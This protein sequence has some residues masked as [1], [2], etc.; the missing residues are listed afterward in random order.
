M[1][2]LTIR[3]IILS[4]LLLV[5]S[6]SVASIEEKNLELIKDSVAIVDFSNPILLDMPRGEKSNEMTT[7]IRT[8]LKRALKDT[9]KLEV[10]TLYTRMIAATTSEEALRLNLDMLPVIEQTALAISEELKDWTALEMKGEEIDWVEIVAKVTD[11]IIEGSLRPAIKGKTDM[12]LLSQSIAF[13]T[14]APFMHTKGIPYS[15]LIKV[16]KGINYGIPY[17]FIDSILQSAPPAK[18]P[19]IIE[20]ISKN[21]AYGTIAAAIESSI[22]YEEIVHAATDAFS[23]S[24]ITI[25]SQKSLELE[26]IAVLTRYASQGIM[27]GT[28]NASTDADLPFGEL[29]AVMIT[30][31]EGNVTIK[32]ASSGLIIDKKEIQVGSSIFQDYEIKTGDDG[33]ITLLF[34]NGTITDLEPNSKMVIDKFT[35]APFD[36]K[37]EKLS[38]LKNEPSTSQTDLNLQYGNLV[39]NV[40]KLNRGSYMN[41]KS[42]LGNAA[43]KG[44]KGKN[45]VKIG[46]NGKI[47]GG[48]ALTSGAVDY[49]R[50]GTRFSQT[51]ETGTVLGN[52]Q[53]LQSSTVS[54]QPGQKITI[55][56]NNSDQ[57]TNTP[58]LIRA[59][60]ITSNE[61]KEISQTTLSQSTTAGE[62]NVNQVSQSI[63][64]V[65]SK[66]G[67]EVTTRVSNTSRIVATG[68]AGAGISAI[69]ANGID[70]PAGQ[71]TAASAQ[72]TATGS[73]LAAR[74]LNLDYVDVAYNISVGTV[75]GAATKTIEFDSDIEN[76]MDSI[77]K[78]HEM[79]V[80]GY[81]ELAGLF[82]RSQVL[83]VEDALKRGRGEGL[84]RAFEKFPVFDPFILINSQGGNQQVFDPVLTSIVN[85]N[86][87]NSS[88]SSSSTIISVIPIV[89]TPSPAGPTGPTG[90]VIVS[91]IDYTTDANL[92]PLYPTQYTKKFYVKFSDGTEEFTDTNPGNIGDPK[93]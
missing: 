46:E 53:T 91:K 76:T 48:L 19:E 72:G 41:I 50:N 59:D 4:S 51:Q 28:V 11:S 13:G 83:A 9:D 66:A 20:K 74:D 40:K 65:Q 79:S 93:P 31:I 49:S 78:G 37:V 12:S 45:S 16:A 10:V 23:S 33:Y 44:T 73:V 60:P 14:A 64:V 92:S 5:C 7:M 86:N 47:T 38:E 52:G 17:K 42:P 68:I 61:A 30:K 18:Q 82:T 54:I 55:E 58:A 2:F 24:A 69:K 26:R 15:V 87:N 3:Q 8:S 81:S 1:K 63:K 67:T 36:A 27:T 22:E 90:P 32:R 29:G 25:A 70:D 77:S 21:T 85:N 39:F 43:I 56:A 80:T 71:I 89:S 6:I 34:S 57:A 75:Q 88:S 84:G 62:T 35:Q